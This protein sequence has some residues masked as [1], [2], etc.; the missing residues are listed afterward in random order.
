MEGTHRDAHPEPL[1][2]PTVME[3]KGA[4]WGAE[5]RRVAESDAQRV[6]EALIAEF[7]VEAATRALDNQGLRGNSYTYLLKPLYEEAVNRRARARA[8]HGAA[9]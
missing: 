8:H 4:D 7:G 2:V 1:I 5:T 6:L 3:N 9:S